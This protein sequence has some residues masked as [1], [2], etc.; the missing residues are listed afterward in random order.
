MENIPS[1][2]SQSKINAK[3]IEDIPQTGKQ[4][5]DNPSSVQEKNVRLIE[6]ISGK[7]IIT[8][9]ALEEKM[10]NTLKTFLR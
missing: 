3:H 2:M 9:L 1:S 5:E 10:L 8:S 6:D 4:I 7:H